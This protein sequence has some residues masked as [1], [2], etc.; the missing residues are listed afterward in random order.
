[1]DEVIATF[2]NLTLHGGLAPNPDKKGGPPT[3]VDAL[4]FTTT[5]S[6]SA[7]PTVIF[8]P[9]GKNLRIAN[10]SVTADLRRRDLH[11]VTVGLALKEAGQAPLGRVRSALYANTFFGS[12]LTASGGS[13]ERAAAEAV[14]QVLT[15]QALS[16]TI[17]VNQ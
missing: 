11:K 13:T 1:M 17:L 3:M 8:E 9:L 2:V 7:T 12:L 16:R 10:A 4:E 15:Q 5:I 14:N 6:G